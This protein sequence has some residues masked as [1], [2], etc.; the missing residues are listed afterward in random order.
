MK[1]S[2]TML[3]TKFEMQ[4]TGLVTLTREKLGG[5]LHGLPC[6]RRETSKKDTA[7]LPRS[8]KGVEAR[9]DVSEK[10]GYHVSARS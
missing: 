3:H 6:I 1:R 2:R 10:L 8:S 4:V 9:G 7:S 5:N